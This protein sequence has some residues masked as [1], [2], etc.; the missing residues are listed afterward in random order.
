MMKEYDTKINVEERKVL[1]LMTELGNKIENRKRKN[2]A[3]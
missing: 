2:K 1:E 3:G